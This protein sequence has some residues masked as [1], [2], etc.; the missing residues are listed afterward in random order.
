MQYFI[1]LKKGAILAKNSLEWFV[2]D[3]FLAAVPDVARYDGYVAATQKVIMEQTPCAWSGSAVVHI[4]FNIIKSFD[5][6]TIKVKN[7]TK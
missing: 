6:N 5:R 4:C 7:Q 2:K 3:G 1:F